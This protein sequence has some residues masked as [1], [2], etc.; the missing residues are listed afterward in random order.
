[1]LLELNEQILKKYG[2]KD[3]YQRQKKLE[4]SQA[5]KV[6]NV[7]LKEIDQIKDDS[8]RWLELF[9]G[10]LAGNI[11]DSGA[12]AVQEIL[13]ANESFGL[14]HAIEKIPERPWL[15]DSFDQFMLRL[16]IVIGSESISLTPSNFI[17]VK[18]LFS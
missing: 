2:F 17:T 15:V 1:M 4:N 10:V 5:I 3:I 7:R 6:L 16:N 9:R 13:Q 12:T 18:C 14:N 8:K 11:F